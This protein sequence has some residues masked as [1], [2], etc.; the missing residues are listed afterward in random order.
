MAAQ[1]NAL[2]AAGA[3]LI[4]NALSTDSEDYMKASLQHG[5]E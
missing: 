2:L 4:A 3:E 5:G 1:G